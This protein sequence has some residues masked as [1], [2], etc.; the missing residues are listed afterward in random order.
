MRLVLV[1]PE[2]SSA[3]VREGQG[4][5][6]VEEDWERTITSWLKENP[7]TS[8]YVLSTYFHRTAVKLHE[9]R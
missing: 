3:K 4:H 7:K 2:P 1:T 6:Y 8:M 5:I 9:Q